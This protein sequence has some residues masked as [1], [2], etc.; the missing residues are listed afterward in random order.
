MQ[1]RYS[2]TENRSNYSILTLYT[3]IAS[4]YGCVN[5]WEYVWIFICIYVF[6]DIYVS[7]RDATLHFFGEQNLVLLMN[8]GRNR[9]NVLRRWRTWD[10]CY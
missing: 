6:M 4:V 10:D 9:K 5:V 7:M 2:L 3:Y 8:K 1:S